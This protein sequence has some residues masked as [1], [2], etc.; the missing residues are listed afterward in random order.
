MS[1]AITVE[2][3]R[4]NRAKFALLIDA[5][6]PKEYREDHIPGSVNLPVVGDEEYAEVGT[7]HRTNTHRAYLIGVRYS[8][9]NIARALPQYIDPLPRHAALCVYC[10]RGGKRSKLWADALDTIGF[11]TFRIEGGWKGYRAFVRKQLETVPLQFEYRVLYGPTGCGKTRLLSALR[12]IGEQTL[13][14]EGLAQHRGSLIGALPGIQQPSQKYFDTLLADEFD[15]F[16]PTRPIWIE[17][18]SKKIGAVAMPDALFKAIHEA[19]L[20]EVSAPMDMRLA[21]WQA[22]FGH[23]LS[24]PDQLIGRLQFLKPIIGGTE[25]NRWAELGQQGRV[26]DIFEACMR[27]H[28]DKAYQRSIQRDYE[29]LAE[30]QRIEL[31]DISDAALER[32]ARELVSS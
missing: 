9:A 32:T 1:S 22:D 15:R 8:L 28:Y 16:D 20:Y 23:F 31:N 14:L 26:V 24:D 3:W 6:S 29:R 30:A 7:E 13:D 12:A 17:A 11:K 21:V 18:E 5:R 4:T 27:H 2:E 25:F 19:R 10:A